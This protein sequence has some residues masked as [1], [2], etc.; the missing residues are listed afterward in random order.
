MTQKVPNE[1]R[2]TRQL[3]AAGASLAAGALL[4]TTALL[5]LLQ[6]ISALAHDE[7]LVVGPD[8]VYA[9]STTAWGWVHIL[10]A[11]L[12]AV[13]A[14]GLIS[15]AT[16][17]RVTAIIMASIS[18]VAMFLWIPYYPVWSMVVIALDVI[19]IWA[20]ATWEPER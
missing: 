15:G 8:Y 17:A 4:L 19:V 13:V 7:L 11:I 1:K 20:V 3:V 2:S 14:I 18:I 5:T 9:L 6:G 10:V 12:L 16:W